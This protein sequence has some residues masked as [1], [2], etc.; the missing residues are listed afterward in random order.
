MQSLRAR[1][2]AAVL[3]ATVLFWSA[4][5]AVIFVHHTRE[6]T[7]QVDATLREIAASILL[8]TQ[9]NFDALPAAETLR[10][11]A[12][13]AY[14]GDIVSYQMW[15]RGGRNIWRSPGA[16]AT[17][18]R[19]DFADGFADREVD[20]VAW[21]VFA[22]SDAGGRFQVQVGKRES[23]IDAA[24]RNK[25]HATLGIAL[26]L[27]ALLVGVIWSV[28]RW[29]LRP[30]SAMRAAVERRESFDLAPLPAQRLP[31]ELRPL[32][33]SFNALLAQLDRAVQR[34]RRFIS[35][36]A[37]ELRTPLA[38]LLAHTEVALR[39][40]NVDEKDAALLRLSA[41][42]ERGARLSEQL[43]DL[44]RLDAGIGTD[45]RSRVALHE[46][47]AVVVRD[48]EHLA[49]RRGQ[50]IAL[51]IEP[52]FVDGDTDELGILARNLVDNA[53]RY[54]GEGGRLAVSCRSGQRVCLTVADNGPGVPE[55]ERSRIFT[56]FYRL[57][58]NGMR[59]S[60]I[61]LSL[62]A[63]IAQSHGAVLEV[64]N[65][66]DGRGLSVA[67]RFDVSAV[68]GEQPPETVPQPAPAMLAHGH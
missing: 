66:L 8:S 39:A 12:G 5:L 22:L 15:L 25:V 51:E 21:R 40:K 26:L 10:L 42:A 29:S 49:E 63:R 56:R 4:L 14:R 43:L 32:V 35:D 41:A 57:A 27:L 6:Q 18:L 58:G 17:P 61:G 19:A 2:L 47:L 50:R 68:T 52:C 62:V 20:A 55:S 7:G 34:E 3:G 64:G 45:R 67:V 65:G 11:P 54:S 31:A 59:G 30:V 33:E 23:Q 36:A 53:L 16:P 38:A 44:A 28:V 1:L 48:F 37:H 13:A 9:A 46:L 60:G 24:L